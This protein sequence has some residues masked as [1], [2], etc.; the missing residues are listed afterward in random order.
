MANSNQFLRIEYVF[1]YDLPGTVD[2]VQVDQWCY[3]IGIVN[4]SESC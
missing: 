2:L 1:T 3:P 4:Y